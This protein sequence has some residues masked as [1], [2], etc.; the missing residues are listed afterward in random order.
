VVFAR[1][2]RRWLRYVR[3][4]SILFVLIHLAAVAGVVLC[5]WS[6]RGAALAVGVYFARMTVVT[7]GYHRYFAH[8]AFRTSRVFQFLLALGAQSAAQRGVLW[9]AGH[10]RW[11]HKHSDTERDVHSAK[12]RGFWFSHMGWLFAD[13]WSETDVRLVPDLHKF[14]ELRWLDRAGYHLLPAVALGLAFLFIGGTP[15]LVWGFLVSTVM[16]WHG[17]FAIN[18]LTHM[19]GRRRYASS[20]RQGFFWWEIDVTYYVLRA[21]A[22]LGL[23]WDLQRVPVQALAGPR[24]PR[25][26]GRT[27]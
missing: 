3:S 7:A 10:H 21:L 11:H 14:P 8:R 22:A 27:R 9:W 24:E 25:R 15:A 26:L 18:S 20:A 17:S 5:G 4:N 1:E 13:T 23:V 16:V 12:R 19:F 2:P 6:W